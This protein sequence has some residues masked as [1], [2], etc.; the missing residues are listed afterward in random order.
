M[1]ELSQTFFVSVAHRYWNP[2]LTVAE[3]RGVYGGA[4]SAEGLGSNLQIVLSAPEDRLATLAKEVKSWLDHRCLFTD[5]ECFRAAPSTLE[6][7]TAFCARELDRRHPGGWLRLEITEGEGLTCA[8]VP[9]AAQLQL[10]LRALN[11]HLITRGTPDENGL[12]WPREQVTQEVIGLYNSDTAST[13]ADQQQ[14]SLSL[15]NLLKKRVKNLRAL[16]I[17]LTRQ[18]YILVDSEG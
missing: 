6:N 8:A 16:R 3:N 17:D 2:A 18:K 13:E 12:L 10:T 15:F 7:I 4:A 14:W 1:P 9:G 11:L 5:D